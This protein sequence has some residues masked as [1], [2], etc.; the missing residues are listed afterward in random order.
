VW[1]GACT[2]TGYGR[3]KVEGRRHAA[4][5]WYYA[6]LRWPIPAGREIDHLCRT[7]ACVNPAHLQPVSHLTNVRRAPKARLGVHGACAIC[8]IRLTTT[9]TLRQIADIVGSDHKTV[10]QVLAGERWNVLEV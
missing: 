10:R 6:Q 8:L 5:R 2:P 3:I 7:R 1:Q 9:L 4:H